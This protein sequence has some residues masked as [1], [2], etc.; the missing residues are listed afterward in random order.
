MLI[1]SLK[2]KFCVVLKFLIGLFQENSVKQNVKD[3]DLNSKGEKFNL[4]SR[5]IQ[6]KKD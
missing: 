1:G 6:L 5:G 2:S 4:K 3:I